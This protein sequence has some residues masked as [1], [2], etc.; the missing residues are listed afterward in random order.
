MAGSPGA[1]KTEFS[2]A[3]LD[4]VEDGQKHKVVRIDVD[5]LRVRMPGYTGSN[6]SLFQGAVS[7][8]VDRMHDMVLANKQSFI[9]DSTFSKFEK[10][11]QNIDRSFGHGRPVFVFYVYQKPEVAW[12]FTKSREVTEGR[13][14]SK[15]AFVREFV[16]SRE[17]VRR[18]F[19][20]YN[21]KVTLVLILKDFE[22]HKVEKL[23]VID[24]ISEFDDNI[25]HMYTEEDLN[26]II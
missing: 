2:K 15:D 18:I 10:A 1:G 20:K 13:N 14:I 23:K 6:S 12:R 21:G 7:I 11:V 25:G 9:L 8:V 22:T 4:I 26:G 16:G 17:T 24:T 19:K 5:E 3:L